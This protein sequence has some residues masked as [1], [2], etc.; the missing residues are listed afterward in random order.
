M[1]FK[2]IVNAE[3]LI[4]K[5]RSG[6]LVTGV[7]GG[8]CYHQASVSQLWPKG[9]ENKNVISIFLVMLCFLYFYSF[10]LPVWTTDIKDLCKLCR[11]RRGKFADQ[12]SAGSFFLSRSTWS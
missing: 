3:Y 1:A 12:N 11:G 10:L 2:Q 5:T 7:G 4:S 8:V 6:D 9:D